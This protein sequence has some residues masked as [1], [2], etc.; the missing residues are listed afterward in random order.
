M[1]FGFALGE[2]RNEGLSRIEITYTATEVASEDEI[3]NGFF[4]ERAKI[5]LDRA[6]RALDKVNDLGWHLPM[7]ELLDSFV[8]AAKQS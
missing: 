6:E 3:L 1:R 5:D 8:T 2:S 7:R 4:A